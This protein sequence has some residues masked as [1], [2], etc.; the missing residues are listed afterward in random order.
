M[1]FRRI[2]G[3]QW[4]PFW[5][6]RDNSFQIG[7]RKLIC[8]NWCVTTSDIYHIV[9]YIACAGMNFTKKNKY[10]N[11]IFI[12][13]TTCNFFHVI[14]AL[15]ILKGSRNSQ[16]FALIRP[17]LLSLHFLKFNFASC[18]LISACSDQGIKNQSRRMNGR[19]TCIINNNFPS[20]FPRNLALVNKM[21]S[22]RRN[23][24]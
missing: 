14:T 24:N 9:L 22:K 7:Y 21:K 23:S 16:G 6:I 10:K 15:Y 4:L 18:I 12:F 19:S 13:F 11:Y 3:V 17:V 20:C 2:M 1:N 8:H 5:P